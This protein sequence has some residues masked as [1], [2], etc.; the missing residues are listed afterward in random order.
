MSDGLVQLLLEDST[1]VDALRVVCLKHYRGISADE[2]EREVGPLVHQWVDEKRQSI[3]SSSSPKKRNSLSGRSRNRGNSLS[4]SRR[5]SLSTSRLHNNNQLSLVTTLFERVNRFNRTTVTWDDV[6]FFLMTES[7]S[8]VESSKI[9]E[10]VRPYSFSRMKEG[11]PIKEVKYIPQNVIDKTSYQAELK[12]RQ[13]LALPDRGASAGKTREKK[14]VQPSYVYQRK[15]LSFINA[16]Y[17]LPYH[18]Y[19]FVISTRSTPFSFFNKRSLELIKSFPLTDIGGEAPSYVAYLPEPDLYIVCNKAE[20]CIRCWSD[21]LSPVRTTVALE[22]FNVGEGIVSSLQVSPKDYPYSFFISDNYG[23]ITR[24]DVPRYMRDGLKLSVGRVYD[25]LHTY[26]SGG[27]SDF[28]MSSTHSFSTGYDRRLV[29]TEL[30]SG[31]TSV[32][33]TVLS[34]VMTH[35]SYCDRVHSV[36]CAMES[37]KLIRV[38]DVT[39]EEDS[40]GVLMNVGDFA[41]HTSTVI[42]VFAVDDLSQVVTV[43]REGEVR[44]WDLRTIRC[45]QAIRADGFSLEDHTA[46][47]VYEDRKKNTAGDG[48][49]VY[50]RAGDIRKIAQIMSC[51]YFGDSHEIVSCTKDSIFCLQ[52]NFLQHG[53]VCDLDVVSNVMW[54]SRNNT[55]LLQGPTRISVWSAEQ[56]YRKVIVDR[57]FLFELSNDE[58]EVSASCL[59]SHGGRLFLALHDGR[60]AVYAADNIEELIDTIDLIQNDYVTQLYYAAGRKLLMGITNGGAI[61]LLSEDE[62]NPLSLYQPVSKLPLSH[63]VFCEHSGCLCFSDEDGN[64]YFY[65]AKLGTRQLTK[66]YKASCD[67]PVRQLLFLDGTGLLLSCHGEGV[68]VVWAHPPLTASP[69]RLTVFNLFKELKFDDFIPFHIEEIGVSYER[70]YTANDSETDPRNSISR[71]LAQTRSAASRRG[72]S[73]RTGLTTATLRGR[74]IGQEEEQDTPAHVAGDPGKQIEGMLGRAFKPKYIRKNQGE[75]TAMCFNSEAHYLYIGDS[76]GYVHVFRLCALPQFYQVKKGFELN[77]GLQDYSGAD[78]NLLKPAKISSLE[79]HP[80]GAVLFLKWFPSL[81]SLISSGEDRS[82]ELLD[83]EGSMVSFLA[84]TRFPNNDQIVKLDPFT[85]PKKRTRALSGDAGDTSLFCQHAHE[86]CLDDMPSA[87]PS[88]SSTPAVKFMDDDTFVM[89]TTAETETPRKRTFQMKKKDH[90]SEKGLFDLDENNNILYNASGTYVDYLNQLK[91]AEMLASRQQ[92]KKEDTSPLGSRPHVEETEK[93]RAEVLVISSADSSCS[94]QLPVVTPADTSTDADVQAVPGVMEE[95]ADEDKF[96][97]KRKEGEAIVA[98]GE[99]H[100]MTSRPMNVAPTLFASDY[101]PPHFAWMENRRKENEAFDLKNVIA[102]TLD[103]RAPGPKGTNRKGRGSRSGPGNTAA[104]QE[105]KARVKPPKRPVTG[106]PCSMAERRRNEALS[107]SKKYESLDSHFNCESLQGLV[108]NYDKQ[109]KKVLRGSSATS[110][111]SAVDTNYKGGF[112]NTLKGNQ[113]FM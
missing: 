50:S 1:R 73:S 8:L 107:V 13:E 76:L 91:E 80:N 85:L 81:N 23:R 77:G 24:M 68:I 110:Q 4:Q 55:F 41:N 18:E 84:L 93:G 102:K 83:Q 103:N 74:L 48:S 2:F 60:I 92:R 89:S 70:N 37:S 40:A 15:D 112:S 106:R 111:R 31:S 29:R 105:D 33:G 67:T 51:A 97:F 86:A 88:R 32:L 75:I 44:V 98:L 109:L 54:N 9:D 35:L 16:I 101:E 6:L 12:R 27:I 79:V 99:I 87:P 59:D 25:G 71:K 45:I 53:K 64:V 78:A 26:E 14:K 39:T 47:N 30:S 3:A 28:V 38:F 96:F 43:D 58:A 100:D 63:L 113:S 7:R 22:P 56:G 20:R 72:V 69:V 90:R 66:F 95:A 34:D 46:E 10:E 36:I 21:L 52:H 62:Y 11:E 57:A 104:T 19:A 49:N 65:E 94:T 82:V 17:S 5:S 61:L 108:S 42:G